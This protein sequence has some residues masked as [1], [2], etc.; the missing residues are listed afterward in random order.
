MVTMSTPLSVDPLVEGVVVA[1][2]G[3]P[4]RS[5]SCGRFTVGPSGGA[6]A[7]ARLLLDVLGD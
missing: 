7:F 1:S 5:S 2:W 6:H 4:W 3:S